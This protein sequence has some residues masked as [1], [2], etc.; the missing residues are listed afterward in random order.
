MGG[1]TFRPDELAFV[2][3]ALTSDDR[4]KLD[5]RDVHDWVASLGRIGVPSLGVRPQD[6]ATKY[7]ER[8]D[9]GAWYVLGP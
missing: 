1:V 5:M 7:P 9:A 2:T 6:P 8:D 3:G 4:L